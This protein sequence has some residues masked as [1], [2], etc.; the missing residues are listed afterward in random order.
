MSKLVQYAK[1]E[2]EL[3]G[4]FD[5]EKDFYG[6]MTGNAVLELVECFANQGHSG[7]SAGIVISLFKSLASWEPINPIHCTDDEWM[8]V[9]N[10]GVFQNKRLSSVFKDGKDGKPYF[11]DAIVWRDKDGGC[12]TGTV[13]VITSRQFIKLPF[14]P[15]TFYVDVDENRNIINPNQLKEVFEYYE[16][17][18]TTTP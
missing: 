11:L 8:E 15:K 14:L 5:K 18:E 9:S 13:G 2:L 6:G 1:S 7:M 12:F 10:D 3:A 4:L 16:P 17:L